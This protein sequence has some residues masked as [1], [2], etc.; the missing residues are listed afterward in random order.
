MGK[1]IKSEYTPLDLFSYSSPG[2]RSLTNGGHYFSLDGSDLLEEYN[3]NAANGGDIADWLPAIKGDSYGDG[4]LGVEGQVTPTD[5]R[6]LDLLGWKRTPATVDDFH[7]R[8]RLRCAL[9]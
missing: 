5:L 8:R 4:H 3:N 9:A 7:R 2:V 6:E 1:S